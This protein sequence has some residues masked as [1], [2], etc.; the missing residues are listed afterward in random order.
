MTIHLTHYPRRASRIRSVRDGP[1]CSSRLPDNDCPRDRFSRSVS[2]SLDVRRSLPQSQRESPSLWSRRYHFRRIQRYPRTRLP[3]RMLTHADGR[4]RQGSCCPEETP[5]SHRRAGRRWRSIIDSVASSP[6]GCVST[7]KS[8]N[9]AQRTRT[10]SRRQHSTHFAHRDVSGFLT[11]KSRIAKTR[12][13]TRFSFSTREIVEP[14][15]VL[16]NFNYYVNYRDNKIPEEPALRSAFV[17]SRKQL[18]DLDSEKGN[19]FSLCFLSQ[20]PFNDTIFLE[21]CKFYTRDFSTSS[22]GLVTRVSKFDLSWIWL[23]SRA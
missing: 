3:S 12:A 23:G 22:N 21:G 6:R 13:R 20:H 11:A 16:S 2:L 8:N 7:E 15:G 9:D 1:T 5:V 14:R 17:R 10:F 19:F 18:N 4:T